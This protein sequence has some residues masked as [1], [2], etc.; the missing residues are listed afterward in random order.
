VK[1]KWVLL[2]G[3]ALFVAI[4]LLASSPTAVGWLAGKDWWLWMVFTIY[5]AIFVLASLSDKRYGWFGRNA[6]LIAGGAGALTGWVIGFFISASN[7]EIL[8][9]MF[10]FA[11]IG[12][13]CKEIGKLL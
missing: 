6:R 3:A 11:T 1:N 9:A 7:V 10:V 8:L 5:L 2:I 13:F 12:I 4:A